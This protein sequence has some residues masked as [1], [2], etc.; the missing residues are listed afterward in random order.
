MLLPRARCLARLPFLTARSYAT[1]S[2]HSSLNVPTIGNLDIPTS[3]FM[4]V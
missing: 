1:S 2:T 4:F 3:L